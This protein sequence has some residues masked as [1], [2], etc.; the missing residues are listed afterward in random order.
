MYPVVYQDFLD[1]LDIL[2][3]DI[4]L[5]FSSS[6][7]VDVDFHGKLFMS[8]IIPIVLGLFMLTT[9]FI[10]KKMCNSHEGVQ[11]I[12]EKHVSMFILLTFFVY[13][14][15]SSVLFQMFSCEELDDGKNYLR[16]DY[17]IQC[18]SN[19]HEQ[20]QMYS[21]FMM[22]VYTIGIPIWYIYLMIKHKNTDSHV[23]DQLSSSYKPNRYYYEI[24]ECIRRI[25]L[26]CVIVFLFPDSASQ[27]A[28]TLVIAFTFFGI[29]EALSPYSNSWD[30]WISMMGHVIIFMSMYIG[31]LLKVDVS[32]ERSESQESFGILLI[33]SNVL[34]IVLIIVEGV[35]LL[36]GQAKEISTPVHSLSTTRGSR[37]SSGDVDEV[38]EG[39]V[40]V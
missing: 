4:G 19:K 1:Y 31:L 26:T 35:F 9:F 36:F 7:I 27:I 8:T 29:S 16:A 34:L 10:G 28:I 40:C 12:K 5:F 20:L 38:D 24:V 32:D 3:F 15:V 37:G 2:N 25:M 22:I 17:S 6:C 18:D 23:M 39:V 33:I 14:N 21:I 13:S 30:R 11:K